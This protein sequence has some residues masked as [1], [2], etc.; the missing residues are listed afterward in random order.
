MSNQPA[1]GSGGSLYNR[2]RPLRFEEM[3]GQEHVATALGNALA[4]GRPA[5]GYLFSGPRGTGKTTTARILARCLNCQSTEGPTRTPC[6]KCDSC[7][8]TGHDDWLDVVEVDA[9]SSA[10]RIDEMRDWLETVRYAPVSARYRVTIMDEAH[11]IQE[12]AASALLKTL[13]EPPPHLVVILCTTHPWDILPTI[14]S[15]VQHF[16]LRK[17]GVSALVQVLARVAEQEGIDASEAALDT[18]ARAADGSYRDAL[19]LLDQI[20]A[21]SDGRVEL[22]QV[23]GLLGAVARESLFELVDLVA[24]G[25]ASGAF[26][27]L[28]DVLDSGN[29]PEQLLRG[30]VTQLRYVCLLQQGASAQDEW[31]FAEDEVS[32][33]RA[34]ANQL[35]PAQVV[36]ALDLLSDAHLRIQHGGADPRLQLEL[37]TAK[38]ARPALDPSLQGLMARIEHLE[39]GRPAAAPG[40]AA[41][42]P[43]PEPPPP[44]PI[45]ESRA[46][47]DAPA[48]E[49]PAPRVADASPEAPPLEPEP[50]EPRAPVSTPDPP[51]P[52]PQAGV[53]L[54]VAHVTRLWPQ[55]LNRLL[56][57]H[58]PLH[59]FVEDATIA[60][61]DG[62][63]IK[64]LVGGG[65]GA[66]MLSRAEHREQLEHVLSSVFGTRVHAQVEAGPPPPAASARTQGAP[67]G[68]HTTLDLDALRQAVINTFDATEE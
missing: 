32:R 4:S 53:T 39:R 42:S 34:Q 2:H 6:M 64:L 59:S 48:A 35:S 51:P 47:D 52:P 13:E 18:L 49:P 44:P 11:Q 56:S 65:V 20:A 68:E 37:V 19:G 38:L 30:L 43:A 22:N 40:E 21:Y 3:V 25:D 28:E 61:V 55:V 29:D 58:P 63:R 12:G 26:A 50:A 33:L 7:L 8:R 57:E 15:R 45:A 36:R 5:R 27:L 23:L 9:A 31:A 54:D 67:S 66:S 16:V 17:P 14:R 62:D 10:R 24:G 46:A 41:S 60:E 1:S